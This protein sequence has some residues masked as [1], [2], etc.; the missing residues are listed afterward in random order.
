MTSTLRTFTR[1]SRAHG[2]GFAVSPILAVR[3]H[4]ST[5]HTGYLPPSSTRAR[6]NLACPAR[7]TKMS[8][9]PVALVS[10]HSALWSSAAQRAC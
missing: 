5:Y 9:T 6:L 3:L 8:R 10:A 2:P 1:A 4:M 7:T